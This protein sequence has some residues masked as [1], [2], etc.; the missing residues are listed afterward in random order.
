M[1][2]DK[3]TKKVLKTTISIYS[4]M[5]DMLSAFAV[6]DDIIQFGWS[7]KEELVCVQANG[8]V[9]LYDL[10][11]Q[12]INTITLDQEI[13]DAKVIDAKIFTGTSYGTGI[14][15]LTTSLTFYLYN[16]IYELKI[17][18]LAEI[19]VFN[20][21]PLCWDVIAY[22]KDTKLIVS[23]ENKELVILKSLDA[24]FQQ[25]NPL[26]DFPEAITM[27]SVSF[28]YSHICF[29]TETGKLML[30]KTDNNISYYYSIFE[31]ES[32]AKPRQLAWCGN[33]A[34]AGHWANLIFF[35]DLNKNWLKYSTYSAIHLIQEID[36][37][38]VVDSQCQELIKKV[39]NASIEIFKIGSFSSGANLLEANRLF[40]LQN[41]KADD[42]IRLIQEKNEMS[43]A[44]KICLEAASN[45]FNIA[46]QKMLLRAALFGKSFTEKMDPKYYVDVCQ[47]LKILNAIRR[48]NVGIALTLYQLEKIGIHNLIDRL[49]ERKHFLLALRIASYLKIAPEQGDIKILTRWAFFKVRQQDK[50]EEQIANDIANKL[51]HY[52]GVSYA[53]IANKAIEYGRK[54]LAIKLLDYELKPTDQ[55]PL[56]LKLKQ[57][58]VALQRAIESGDTNLIYVVILKLKEIH[59]ASEFLMAIREYS[60]AYALFQKV[61]YFCLCIS[62]FICTIYSFCLLS[63]LKQT[64]KR[65]SEIFFSK[66]IIP[67][68]KDCVV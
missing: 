2:T 66:K 25:I 31:T 20:T 42:Y 3:V 9:S 59:S 63:S 50:N 19:P 39:E 38:R 36:S 26:N 17:R 49:I 13:R 4:S 14:A 10:F 7:T 61:M 18:R 34:V 54:N 5:G 16:N 15:I 56:L 48:P 22:G 55:V 43:E 21:P 53:E 60:V 44:V 28:D 1:T 47:K 33:D 51:Q 35:V 8:F 62:H 40:E 41:H 11:G 27:L 58:R 52:S 65:S 46:T 29:F 45:E 64:T 30:A 12:H 24:S 67:H 23:K 57:Y 32:R 6:Q 37:L 68:P